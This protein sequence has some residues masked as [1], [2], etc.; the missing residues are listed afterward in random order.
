MPKYSQLTRVFS[1]EVGDARRRSSSRDTLPA[2]PP[3]CHP[4]RA[5]P[6]TR[7]VAGPGHART[8]AH[9]HTSLSRNYSGIGLD[10]LVQSVERVKLRHRRR[11]L[12]Y[13]KSITYKKHNHHSS[14]SLIYSILRGSCFISNIM[15]SLFFILKD[16]II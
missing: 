13:R 5:T 12:N 1:H 8:H 16:I 15:I 11:F 9:S 14:W 3:P 4:R 10:I 7:H 2:Q 6:N